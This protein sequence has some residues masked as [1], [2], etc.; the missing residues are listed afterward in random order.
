MRRQHSLHMI[1]PRR[2]WPV[3]NVFLLL[4]A[5]LA[6]ASPCRAAGREAGWELQEERGFVFSRPKDWDT[7]DL[8]YTWTDKSDDNKTIITKEGV[9][10]QFIEIRYRAYEGDD[11]FTKKKLSAQLPPRE[12]ADIILDE[13]TTQGDFSGVTVLE[14]RPVTI[15]G[16]PAFRAVLSYREKCGLLHKT[17]YCGFIK[18]DK[19]FSFWYAAPAQHYFDKYLPVFDKVLSSFK[20]VDD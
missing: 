6:A 8:K 14:N 10:L 19:Y 17:V 5:V 15:G 1:R 3:L 12:L 2:G 16:I 11:Q 7:A 18:D 9:Y 4:F 13:W 20:L